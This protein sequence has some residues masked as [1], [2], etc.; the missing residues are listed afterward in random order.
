[1]VLD[2]RSRT[3]L[4]EHFAARREVIAERL[5]QVLMASE[6]TSGKTTTL[7]QEIDSLVSRVVVLLLADELECEVARRLGARLVELG[8]GT[9]SVLAQTHDVLGRELV[10]DLSAGQL[11]SLHPR[12]IA[13]LSEFA[14]G[15]VS[16]MAS[17]LR[18]VQESHHAGKKRFQEEIQV[19]VEQ[20]P[21]ILFAT[22]QH[23]F[24]TFCDGYGLA[25][26]GRRAEELVGRSIWEGAQL[27]PQLPEHVRRAL[28]GASLCANIAVSGVVFQV[29]FA[30]MLRQ[31]ATVGVIGVATDITAQ[32]RAE[33]IVHCV[34][35][36]LTPRERRVLP[37]LAQP[38]LGYDD[39]G[40]RLH[41]ESESVRSYAKSIAN[42]LGVSARRS[43]L[44][45]A[46]REHEL[47]PP[48]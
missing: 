35:I 39:I 44:A 28:D 30:P 45:D 11:A 25:A 14:V 7:R 19:V 47:L 17:K 46:I 43:M 32:V 37:L 21:I 13:L 10:G 34:E 41:L 12:L 18:V 15:F 26:I 33:A 4:E 16:E 36:G 23:G 6:H 9:S 8:F 48:S 27:I 24:L 2:Y 38:Q 42:K 40:A 22:N 29:H 20:A 31:G 5:Y 1:M 3:L